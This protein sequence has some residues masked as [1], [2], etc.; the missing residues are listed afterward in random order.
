M[1]SMDQAVVVFFNFIEMKKIE[2]NN[3]LFKN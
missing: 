1:L 2:K 3:K